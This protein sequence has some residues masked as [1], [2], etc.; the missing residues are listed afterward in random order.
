[1]DEPKHLV[2]DSAWRKDLSEGFNVALDPG[3]HSAS[4]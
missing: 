3:H 1:V 2:D 4:W